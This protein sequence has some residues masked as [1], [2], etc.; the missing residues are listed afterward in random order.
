MSDNNTKKGEDDD[1]IKAINNKVR[2]K[3]IQYLLNKQP[4]ASYNEIIRIINPKEDENNSTHQDRDEHIVSNAIK[5][6]IKI[7]EETKIIQRID[8]PYNYEKWK[9]LEENVNPLIIRE[10]KK[11][12]KSEVNNSEINLFFLDKEKFINRLDNLFK[13]YIPDIPYPPPLDGILTSPILISHK[14]LVTSINFMRKITDNGKMDICFP[15]ESAE[16]VSTDYI[17]TEGYKKMKERGITI[18]LITEI[19]DNIDF[20]MKIIEQRMVD[21]IRILKKVVCGIAV[22]E[23]Q[24]MNAAFDKDLMHTS[25]NDDNPAIALYHTKEEAVKMYQSVFDTMWENAIPIFKK[26]L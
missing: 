1:F 8:P 11:K 26:I 6:H 7:L 2:D 17:Y 22:S 13:R 20:L 18:R 3:I 4:I 10:I 5:K 16:I 15:S 21:E 12:Y 23:K 9:S 14:V 19:K 25:N 24:C